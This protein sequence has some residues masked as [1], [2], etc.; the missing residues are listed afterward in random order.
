MAQNIASVLA[1]VTAA[2]SVFNADIAASNKNWN[3]FRGWSVAAL[4]AAL[5]GYLYI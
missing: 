2:L 5:A 3:S 1:L 4:Y